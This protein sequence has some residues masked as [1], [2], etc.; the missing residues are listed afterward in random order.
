MLNGRGR[1]RKAYRLPGVFLIYHWFSSSFYPDDIG[2]HSDCLKQIVAGS[3]K[4][5]R[6]CL[7]IKFLTF[8]V[9][10]QHAQ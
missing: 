1:S 10:N 7:Q 9:V 5:I 6:R 4:L 2:M 8:K 3:F